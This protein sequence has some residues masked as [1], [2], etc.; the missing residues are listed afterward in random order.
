M[1]WSEQLDTASFGG[2]EFECQA[3]EDS[4]VRRIV[5]HKYPYRDGADL[6]DLGREP[7]P[8]TVTAVF[9]GPTYEADL[10]GFMAWVDEGKTRDFIHPILGKWKAKLSL[11]G[12]SHTH[13]ARDMCTVQV[14]VIE[15]GTDAELDTLFSIETLEAEIILRA[16]EVTVENTW[17]FDDVISAV[18]EAKDFGQE[19]ASKINEVTER[20]NAVRKKVETAIQTIQSLTD[21]ASYPLFRSIMKMNHACHKLA[22]RV[23]RTKPVIVRKDI[24]SQMPLSLLAH[25]LYGDSSRAGTILEMNKAI[26]N[27]FMPPEFMRIRTPS[28]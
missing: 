27:P 26:K 20:V 2:V 17:D 25:R 23:H 11:P 9:Y 8:T 1:S 6:E 13:S 24:S 21:V 19:A 15:D 10:S 28:K 18:N 12:I 22:D 4:L 3:L 5:Q 16:D 14:D 7:R